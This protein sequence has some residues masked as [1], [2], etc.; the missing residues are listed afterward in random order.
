[1]EKNK[2]VNETAGSGFGIGP[3]W[4]PVV[5]P[6]TVEIPFNADCL[7]SILFGETLVDCLPDRLDHILQTDPV[8]IEPLVYRGLS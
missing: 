1:M 8:C 4:R 7:A 6:V 5:E 3:H 2:P